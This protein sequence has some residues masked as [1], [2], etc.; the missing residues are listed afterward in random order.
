MGGV[1]GWKRGVWQEWGVA[2]VGGSRGRVCQG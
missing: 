2:G 1:V